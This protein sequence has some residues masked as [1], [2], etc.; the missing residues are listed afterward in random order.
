MSVN[1]QPQPNALRRPLVWVLPFQAASALTAFAVTSGGQVLRT[2]LLG[3]L[4]CLMTLPLLASL[5]ACLVALMLFEPN[6]GLLRRA[7]YLLVEYSAFDPIHALSPAVTFLAFAALVKVRGLRILWESALAVPFSVLTFIYCLQIFNPLQG[8]F[9]V[10]VS[11]V[12][13]MLVPMLWFYFGQA[14]KPQFMATALRLLIALG[15]VCSLHGIYQLAAGFPPFEQYWMDNTEF[16]TSLNVGHVKRAFATFSSAEEWGR[17]IE[18]GAVAAFGFALGARRG[19]ARLGY[20]A[21]GL[22]LAAM[23]FVTGQRSSIFGMLAGIAALAL[24]GAPTFR[25]ACGRLALM[26]FCGLLVVTL[27]KP[28]SEDDMWSKGSD[29]KFETMLSHSARGT[30]NPAKEASLQERFDMWTNLM[31]RVV[32][33]RPLG[34]GLG[35]GS[36]ASVRFNNLKELMPIDSFFVVVII[37]CGVPAALILV[38]VL[39]R[40]AALA[41]VV[42][43]RAAPHTPEAT[44]ARVVA[45]LLPALILN[46]VIGLTFS[47]YSCAPIGWLLVG[48]V[49]AEATR[50]RELEHEGARREEE[51][52]GD[53]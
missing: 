26:V 29:E 10:G 24:V 18:F 52:R 15:L 45:A 6:R 35:A 4:A 37:A 50:R 19:A 42:A 40:A 3:G 36:L 8:A 7:Q 39:G 13:Y 12:I 11:G 30:L 32:P 5:E 21:A 22:A 41:V 20:A 33:Y 51:E 49:S 53:N 1:L 14:V 9:S 2:L 17:Y 44:V 25:A 27:A 43:R 16:Y 46:N 31:T 34:H 48:W 38:W 23:L 28:P 47:I